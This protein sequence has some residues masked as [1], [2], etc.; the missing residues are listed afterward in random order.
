MFLF[1]DKRNIQ[2]TLYKPRITISIGPYLGAFGTFELILWRGLQ[3]IGKN[4]KDSRKKTSSRAL[5]ESGKKKGL[6]LRTCRLNICQG[7][8]K[9]L[10]RDLGLSP[11]TSSFDIEILE[12]RSGGFQQAFYTYTSH[13]CEVF[14][15]GLQYSLKVKIRFLDSKSSPHFLC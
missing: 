11:F 8:D 6:K 4:L 9:Q 14:E 3:K 15:M 2:V 5:N 1:H 7:Q 10:L 12:E 13:S